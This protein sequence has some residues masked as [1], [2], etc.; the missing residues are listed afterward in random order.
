MIPSNLDCTRLLAILVF[1]S[2]L[3]P[4]RAQVA[5]DPTWVTRIGGPDNEDIR[6]VRQTSDEGYVAVGSVRS[7]VVWPQGVWWVSEVYLIRLDSRGELLWER[8]LGGEESQSREG[9]TVEET[10]DG[11]FVVVGSGPGGRGVGSSDLIRLESTGSV[12]WETPFEGRRISH[13]AVKEIS[14]GAL[15][16]AGWWGDVFLTAKVSSDGDILSQNEIVRGVPA[17]VSALEKTSDDGYITVGQT[18][19]LPTMESDLHLVRL[20]SDSELAWDTVLDRPGYQFGNAVQE[21][22]DGGYIVAGTSDPDGS[23]YGEES[24]AFV[25]KLDTEGRVEWERAFAEPSVA[26]AVLQANE[27]GYLVAGGIGLDPESRRSACIWKLDR[28]GELDSAWGSERP[29]NPMTF[30]GEPART[31]SISTVTQSTDGGYVAAGT[32]HPC[33]L[34]GGS[35]DVFLLKLSP[36][37][38]FR[39][40][41]GNDDGMVDMSDAICTLSWLFLGGPA[42]GCLAAAD[43]NADDVVDISD[44]GYLLGFLFLGGPAPVTPFPD[45]GTSNLEADTELGCEES[46]CL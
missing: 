12:V 4:A 32:D 33:Y 28:A 35:S 42:P 26:S 14:D 1:A 19:R 39:R 45:C 38:R 20:D 21:T 18:M 6:C 10:S 3:H 23:I 44:A 13:A 7:L 22:V 17:V 11:G 16:V 15:L 41:D 30:H 46:S 43:T 29:E 40:G 34:C 5:L 37:S 8:T 31:L 25:V 9:L 24:H 27:G 2:F 36:A